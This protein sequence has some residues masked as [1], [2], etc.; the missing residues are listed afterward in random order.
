MGVNLSLTL[1]LS[2]ARARACALSDLSMGV[3]DV[4]PGSR[5]EEE[6]EVLTIA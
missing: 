2:R 4:N 1:S 3:K 5:S 6:G